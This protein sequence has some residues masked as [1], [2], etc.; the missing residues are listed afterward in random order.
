MRE[1]VG[2]SLLYYI[3]IPIIFLFIVF[4]AFIMNYASAYRASNYVISQIETC[5]GDVSHCNHLPK[6]LDTIND[7]IKNKYYYTEGF[8]LDSLCYIQNGKGTVYRVG[9]PVYFDLPLFGRIGVY[10]VISE[11][12]TIYNVYEDDKKVLDSGL[13]KCNS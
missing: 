12:K 2:G 9:L 3:L 11:S 6:G 4:I 5:D 10:N 7:F 8:S 13:K 1:A